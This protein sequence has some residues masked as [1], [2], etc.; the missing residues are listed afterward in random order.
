MKKGLSVLLI[1]AALFGFYG[2]AVNLNDVLAC[3]DYWEEEGE[4]STADMNKL[5]DGLNQL[6]DNE[7]AYLDGLEKVADGE[8]ALAQGEEDYAAGQ[9]ELAKGEADYAAAPGKL[10]AG[11]KE[12]A[13][14]KAKLAAGK[15][16]LA[17]GKKD[18]SSLNTLIDGVEQVL[19]GYP[20]WKSG[21]EQ[22]KEGRVGSIKK[23]S[24][25][26]QLQSVLTAYAQ[27]AGNTDAALALQDM[28]KAGQLFAA[29]DAT[30]FTNE[31][32][33][34]FNDYLN[35]MV[36][37]LDDSNTFF[38]N[39]KTNHTTVAGNFQKALAAA[40][41][42]AQK[43]GTVATAGAQAKAAQEQAQKT[44]DPEDVKAAQAAGQAAR[45]Q[46]RGRNLKRT[47][48]GIICQSYL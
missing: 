30:K 13:A 25:T 2:G 40:Q 35:A 31:Q 38:D 39:L 7:Q 27:K 44:G 4:R 37:S 20:E 19:D 23:P 46:C 16:A 29:Q 42:V 22:L 24:D 6:K 43:Y 36:K 1:A 48:G 11:E 12:L 5:E 34:G 33:D 9:A 15:A 45:G 8:E 18:L 3:K 21:Y 47:G 14:G 28:Q 41:P 32:Y 10:A 26:S 17:Q